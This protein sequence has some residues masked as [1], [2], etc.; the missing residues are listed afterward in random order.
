MGKK[1]RDFKLKYSLDWTCGVG[2]SKLKSD[3]KA[4]SRT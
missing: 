4:T 2:I 1:E 3:I